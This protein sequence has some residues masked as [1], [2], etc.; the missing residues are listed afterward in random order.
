MNDKIMHQY[1]EAKGLMMELESTILQITKLSELNDII[2]FKEVEGHNL[3]AE[4]ERCDNRLRFVFLA[5]AGFVFRKYKYIPTITC[6]DRTQEEQDNIYLNHSN[7]ETRKQYVLKPW[8]SAHQAKLTPAVRA[9]DFR[10]SDMPEA[11]LEDTK[12]FLSDD[13]V[14]Y[15]GEKNTAL[16]HNVIGIHFHIQCDP[17]EYTSIKRKT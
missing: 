15:T 5:F 16:H 14:V 7:Q 8:F 12:D 2:N 10:S 11:V 1:E 13:Q 6:I 3:R 17:D 9:L 4:F